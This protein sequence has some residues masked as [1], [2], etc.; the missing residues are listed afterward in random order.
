MF[1]QSEKTRYAH[2]EFADMPSIDYSGSSYRLC[3]ANQTSV[4]FDM[5]KR[6]C[7]PMGFKCTII[8]STFGGDDIDVVIQAK[9]AIDPDAYKR[10]RSEK[11]WGLIRQWN[12][13]Y[14]GKFLA[15][16]ECLHEL[17]LK[18]NLYFDCGW[19]GNCGLFGSHDVKRNSYCGASS[20]SSWEYIIDH[21]S[22]LIHDTK[23]KLTKAVYVLCSTSYGKIDPTY[24]FPEYNDDMAL[25]VARELRPDLKINW[26]M[27]KR[28][29]DNTSDNYKCLV[30]RDEKGH[31][32][33]SFV[34]NKGMHDIVH[35]TT[36]VPLAGEG[37]FKTKKDSF[38]K[39]MERELRYITN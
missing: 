9:T 30:V 14:E 36:R 15:L 32:I 16:H 3:R 20:L 8:N 12:K 24:M 29:C 37:R 6:I 4:D 35:I 21:W 33:G 38:R 39:D 10:A 1:T 27:G 31:Y 13:E 34:I 25:Q 2:N 19:V 26:E 28:P 23:S 5:V 17:D 7:E 22:P 18:T 11:N